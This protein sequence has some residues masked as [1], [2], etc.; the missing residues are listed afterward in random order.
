MF[1]ALNSL[2]EMRVFGQDATNKE[3]TFKVCK[4][5]KDDGSDLDDLD[6][7]EENFAR[8]LKKDTRKYRGK[9]PFKCFNCGKIGHCVSKFPIKVTNDKQKDHKG[10]FVKKSYYVEKDIGVSD[11]EELNYLDEGSDECLSMALNFGTNSTNLE[12]CVKG[13]VLETYHNIEGTMLIPFHVGE[14]KNYWIIGSGFSNPMASDE[15]KFFNLENYDGALVM[16]GDDTS[17]KIYGKRF[18]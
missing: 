10:K 15:I 17:A 13:S 9:L 12:I 2:N 4:V 18:N 8:R 16:F 11:G 5:E 1:G 7:V 14:E 3:T 6:E